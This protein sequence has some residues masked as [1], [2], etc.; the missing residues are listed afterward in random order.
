MTETTHKRVFW[1]LV[2]IMSL[3]GVLGT[4]GHYAFQP[5]VEV[6]IQSGMGPSPAWFT[7]QMPRYR[8][9]FV[10]TFLHVVPGFLLMVMAPMQLS[11]R[12]RS[13]W[14]TVHRIIGRS[15]VAISF[16]LLISG[17]VIGFVMPFDGVLESW[18]SLFIAIG[19]MVCMLKGV[20]AIRKGKVA[21][22]RVY[23]SYMLAF[24]YT[25]IT[26]RFI[27]LVL[28]GVFGLDGQVYFAES[29]L[30]AAFINLLFV[31][32]WLRRRRITAQAN[33]QGRVVFPGEMKSSV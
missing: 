5:P 29:M 9:H 6:A 27:L 15:F 14:P 13:A 21:Q 33:K 26:M 11:S 19:F 17:A 16:V 4:I 25:P 10:M 3:T 18:G 12:I 7:E 24:A 23:M 1:G 31:H 28:V 30:A 22:H 20:Q 2:I 32:R 8:Q